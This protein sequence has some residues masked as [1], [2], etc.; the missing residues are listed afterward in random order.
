MLSDYDNF[1]QDDQGILVDT[2]SVLPSD[3]ESDFVDAQRMPWPSLRSRPPIDFS[4]WLGHSTY[5]T[6]ASGSEINCSATAFS[7]PHSQLM[8]STKGS[9]FAGPSLKPFTKL[10]VFPHSM[11]SLDRD[12][13]RSPRVPPSIIASLTVANL[14][15][16]PHYHNLCQRYDHVTGVLAA[17]VGQ[18]LTESHVVSSNTFFDVS[19]GALFLLQANYS[20]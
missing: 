4:G 2:D 9:T 19:K 20:Y 3:N 11:P 13:S 7:H 12:S 10:S 6:T 8:G 5:S 18:G 16:N 14:H 15:H 1:D 17:Y